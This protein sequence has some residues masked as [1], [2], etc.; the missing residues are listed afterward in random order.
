MSQ[1]QTRSSQLVDEEDPKVWTLAS[2][3]CFCGVLPDLTTDILS[4]D[5][6]KQAES[7]VQSV[8]LEKFG[9]RSNINLAY[10]HGKY[11]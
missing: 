2:S 3:L 7:K 1:C 10:R 11:I 6:V 4:T 9:A 5:K 8:N